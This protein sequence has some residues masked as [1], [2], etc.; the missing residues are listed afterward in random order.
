MHE[1]VL[2]LGGELGIESAHGQGTTIVAWVPLK[3]ESL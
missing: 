2:S 3:E 1:R